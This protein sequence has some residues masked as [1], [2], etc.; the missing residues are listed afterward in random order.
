MSE[1]TKPVGL[2]SY[3]NTVLSLTTMLT[4]VRNEAHGHLLA[5]KT[6]EEFDLPSRIR[7]AT[8][9]L[10]AVLLE[11]NEKLIEGGASK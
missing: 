9:D 3:S 8:S 5:A 1:Q 6:M 2:L 4:T 11:L 7:N 10:I